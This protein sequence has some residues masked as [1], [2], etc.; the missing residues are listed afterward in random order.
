MKGVVVAGGGLL[1]TGE[2]M[3]DERRVKSGWWLVLNL[4]RYPLLLTSYPLQPAKLDY[5]CARRKLAARAPMDLDKSLYSARKG[6]AALA[7]M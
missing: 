5:C 2:D 3:K 6:S 7:V 4:C 1:V